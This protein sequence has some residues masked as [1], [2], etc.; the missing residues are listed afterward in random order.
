MLSRLRKKEI[1]ILYSSKVMPTPLQP[2]RAKREL[3]E[4][5]QLYTKN[6]YSAPASISPSEV[7]LCSFQ[8]PI[9]I[10][11]QSPS[12]R[13]PIFLIIEQFYAYSGF[14]PYYKTPIRITKNIGLLLQNSKNSLS[15]YSY[16]KWLQLNFKLE[17]E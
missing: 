16:Q 2:A 7:G 4:T 10:W 14:I 9:G 5:L 12:K 3:G 6:S 15:P 13:L 17:Y 11:R 1:T 8:R